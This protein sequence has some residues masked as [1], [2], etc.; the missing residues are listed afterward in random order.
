[1]YFDCSSR[2]ALFDFNNGYIFKRMFPFYFSTR[3]FLVVRA[4]RQCCRL[5]I[6]VYTVNRNRGWSLGVWEVSFTCIFLSSFFFFFLLL[7]IVLPVFAKRFF[8]VRIRGVYVHIY[9]SHEAFYRALQ[10][11]CAPPRE[12]RI[13]KFSFFSHFGVIKFHKHT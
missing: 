12:S 11:T 2:L 6:S 8:S 1:M 5:W 13:N 3:T 4:R 9:G 10:I 7:R